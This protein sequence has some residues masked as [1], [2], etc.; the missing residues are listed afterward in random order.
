MSKF[1]E[2]RAAMIFERLGDVGKDVGINFSF[3]G[4]M[5]NTRD[6]HRIV[7]LG[8]T[9][10]PE[11]QTK[12]VEELHAGYF[13]NEKDIT[14]HKFLKSAAVKAGLGEDEVEA[15]L[16]SDKGG[17]E[18]D[19]EVKEAQMKNIGGV[20]HFTV[21]DKYEVG[22]AQDSQAFVEIF[23]KIKAMEGS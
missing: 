8:K 18:V 3:G 22:G 9:K 13:E 4:R 5:G 14:D 12:V 17:N 11:V 19:R 1:G 2:Q 20:P 15:W 10:G 21:Q 6:S 16:E 23:E 7:Q